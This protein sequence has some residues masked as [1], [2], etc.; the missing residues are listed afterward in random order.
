MEDDFSKVINVINE[1]GIIRSNVPQFL[2]YDSVFHEQSLSVRQG[3]EKHKEEQGNCDEIDFI[4]NSPGGLADDA[5]RIIRTLRKSFKTVNIIVPF[6]VKSA[7]T[8]LSLGG[9]TIVMDEY[10]EFGPLDAQLGKER[11][12]SPELERESALNDEHSLRRIEMRFKEMYETMYIRLYEHKKINIPKSE[13]SQQLLKNLSKF[14]EPLLSQINPYKLGDKRRKLDIGGQYA[15]RILAQFSELKEPGKIRSF[16]DFLVDGCP[17]HGYVIDYD[18]MKMFLPN[19]KSSNE[20]YGKDYQRK[21]SELSMLFIGEDYD[22][23]IGFIKPIQDSETK[24]LDK[25]TGAILAV[26][27]SGNV[28]EEKELNNI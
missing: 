17:D 12:D 10:G 14:Y 22:E 25:K 21:L 9:T 2:F 27:N 5:Y 8:L 3:I 4:I 16:V 23:F 7:A 1:L 20:A 24:N 19:I 18:L 26:N 6:W 11:D 28:I 13:L 15:T